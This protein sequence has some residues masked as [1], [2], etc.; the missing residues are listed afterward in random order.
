MWWWVLQALSDADLVGLQVGQSW[1]LDQAKVKG[2]LG[3]ITWWFLVLESPEA[4]CAES[5]SVA[6]CLRV[7]SYRVFPMSPWGKCHALV[8]P[9]SLLAPPAPAPMPSFCSVMLR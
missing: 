8:S 6:G 7:H 3:P 9:S 1:M 2:G 5:L 4:L